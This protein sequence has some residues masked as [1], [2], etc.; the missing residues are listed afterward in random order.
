MDR[1]WNEIDAAVKKEGLAPLK[2]VPGEVTYSGW[3]DHDLEIFR[4][5]IDKKTV[6]ELKDLLARQ[7][8]ILSNTKLVAKLPDK[9]AKVELKKK[10]IEKVIETRTKVID[11][12]TELMNGLKLIDTNALEFNRGG[13]MYKHLNIPDL[14]S[15]KNTQKVENS[16]LGILASKEVPDKAF[17]DYSLDLIQ[18]FD[19][20]TDNDKSDNLS[21]APFNQLKRIELNKKSKD[22]ILL[23]RHENRDGIKTREV[24]VM[25]L[26]PSNYE[27]LKVQQID[28]TESMELQRQQ[29]HRIKDA[30]IQNA[31]DK[32]T[33][34]GSLTTELEENSHE[35]MKWREKDNEEEEEED[36]EVV[37][38]QDSDDD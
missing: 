13:A 25:P 8:I 11:E 34:A 31:L 35:N 32:L 24:E 29:E 26:P 37:E 33:T 28:L 1:I 27:S 23:K 5:S 6:P 30:K 15:E 16:V 9:G 17:Q 36:E 18:K 20:A 4:K 21:K 22:K 12:A 7:N 14:Q 38:A 19:A 2:K 3:K 10:E